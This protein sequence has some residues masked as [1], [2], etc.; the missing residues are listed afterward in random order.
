MIHYVGGVREWTLEDPNI[1]PMD[2]DACYEVGAKMPPGDK[3]SKRFSGAF[4]QVN[5]EVYCI[6]GYLVDPAPGTVTDRN[7]AYDIATDTWRDGLAALPEP[8]A[9][10]VGAA[11]SSGNVYVLGG[12]DDLGV[13]RDTVYRY[14][15]VGDSWDDPTLEA[16]LPV[17]CF[18]YAAASIGDTL[19]VCGGLTS[20]VS[21]DPNSYSAKVYG[22]DTGTKL[23]DLTLDD[24]PQ[25]RRCHAMVAIGTTLYVLGGFYKTD[26]VTGHDLRD[27]WALDTTNPAA[28]W[29]AMA[30]LPF[31]IAGHTAAVTNN[32]IYILGGWTMDGIKYDVIE[33]DPFDGATGSSRILERDGHS[34]SIGWPRYW[35][36][37][38]AWLNDVVS[39]GGFGGGPGNI[40]TTPHS[41][42][43]HFNQVYV[44]DLTSPFDP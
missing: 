6:G 30:D 34:A 11:D 22:Y 29:T 26:D 36:Y 25:G 43:T 41:G 4:V 10:N 15:P 37:T 3:A 18:S 7:Q 23:W 38:G 24:L 33:Y 32:K 31:D 44:Y 35:I 42:M 13:I 5:S 14:D 19:Y 20:F 2:S 39:I 28:V 40:G 21:G 9:F 8:R 16:P 12:V 1:Y 27:V 17:P